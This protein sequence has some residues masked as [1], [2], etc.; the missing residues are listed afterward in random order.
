MYLGSYHFLAGGGRSVCDGRSP[1]FSGPPPCIRKKN[2]V[3][4]LPPGRNFGP[5][6]SRVKKFWSPQDGRTFPSLTLQKFWS[7]PLEH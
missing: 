2:S 3:P 1:I 6:F 4:P 7:P 5:P